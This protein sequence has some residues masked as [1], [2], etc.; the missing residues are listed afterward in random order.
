MNY[1][2]SDAEYHSLSLV[3]DQ[4]KLITGLLAIKDA[5][6][7]FVTSDALYAFLNGREGEIT[8]LLKAIDER[9]E[10]QLRDGTGAMQY[11]D[12]MHA[13]RMAGGD[14]T[15]SPKDAECQITRKLANAAKIDP[16]MEYVLNEWIA[17]LSRNQL[18]ASLEANLKKP[19]AKP[20]K[21][22]KLAASA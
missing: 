22:E 3:R 2:I 21:R 5:G 9:H 8:L 15:H 4:I 10:A 18:T 16:N 14:F 17:V 6:L 7:E 1:Q 19:Q 20:R 12:W 11:F 13:L